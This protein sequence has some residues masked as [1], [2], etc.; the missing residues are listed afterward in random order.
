MWPPQVFSMPNL[1]SEA[2]AAAMAPE[3]YF[4]CGDDGFSGGCAAMDFGTI[5]HY[6]SSPPGNPAD[7]AYFLGDPIMQ[8]I[9]DTN[10]VL[11]ATA[12]TPTPR[13]R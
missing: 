8:I 7:A 6:D 4:A 12:T 13:H 1:A 11:T 5:P 3:N 2:V 10:V 9:G